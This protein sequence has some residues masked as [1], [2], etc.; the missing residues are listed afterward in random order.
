MPEVEPRYPCP[1]CLGAHLEKTRVGRADE[2]ELDYC[3]R[4]G[5]VWFELG[6]IQRLRHQP[7]RAFWN[8]ISPHP[9]GARALCHSCHTPIEPNADTCPGCGSRRTIDCPVCQQP[10]EAQTYQNIRL[11]VCKSCRGVWF[12]HAELASIWKLSLEAGATRR[13]SGGL[14]ASADRQHLLVVDA[15]LY[16]PDVLFLGARAAGYAVTGVAEAAVSSGVAE[17]VAEAAGTVFEAIVEIIGGL[18]S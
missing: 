16:M 17:G 7:S 6:E 8:R 5:G 13:G 10:L 4:C 12:D 18:F 1:V 9:P 3:R 15:L 14:P 11:D 2:L